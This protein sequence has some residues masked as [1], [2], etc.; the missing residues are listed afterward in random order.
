MLARLEAGPFNP[1]LY[2]QTPRDAAAIPAALH[3]RAEQ[4][5]TSSARLPAGRWACLVWAAAGHGEYMSSWLSLLSPSMS[6]PIE[7][8]ADAPPPIITA[9]QPTTTAAQPLARV[10][11]RAEGEL[12]VRTN[13]VLSSRK[14]AAAMRAARR[15]DARG[16]ALRARGEALWARVAL[17]GGAG[18][19]FTVTVGDGRQDGRR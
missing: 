12:P 7:D 15:C 6:Y 13:A 19:V 4:R 10:G 18:G 3:C 2:D 11:G 14:D 17:H 5:A 8:N 1:C 16:E 9:V